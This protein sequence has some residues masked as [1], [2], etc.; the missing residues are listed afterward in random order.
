MPLLTCPDNCKS[1][2]TVVLLLLLFTLNLFSKWSQSDSINICQLTTLQ[3]LPRYSE[4]SQGAKNGLRESSH[5][6]HLWPHLYHFLSGSFTS[7]YSDYSIKCLIDLLSLGT[8][9]VLDRHSPCSFTL[10]FILSP[11]QWGL[12]SLLQQ[13][14]GTLDVLSLICFSYNSTF[15]TQCI[16]SVN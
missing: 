6:L 11:S 16:F 14:A 12:L 8:C 9:F 4:S 15:N 1:L 10:C 7:S 2:L 3:W 5:L 13:L